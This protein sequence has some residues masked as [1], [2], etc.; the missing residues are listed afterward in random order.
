MA[1]TTPKSWGETRFAGK[2][3]PRIDGY[4]RVSG[5]ATY[6]S[7]VTL[8]DMLYGAI[9]RCPYGHA[10]VKRVDTSVARTM[11]G[12][13]AVL[14]DADQEA[15]IPWYAQP[16]PPGTPVRGTS[17]LFDPH[18]RYEGEE[19]A[20]VAAETPQQAW[21]AVR[22][23]KVEYD[24][25]PA[26]VDM[27]EALKPNA[28]RIHEA[29]NSVGPARESKRGNVELGFAE[30]DVVL[31][32]TYRTSCE[33]HTCLELHGSVVRWDG[34]RLTVWDTNQ[35]PFPIQAALASTLNMPLSKVRVIST[36]MGGGFG[37]KLVL[38][39]YTVIAALFAKKTAR[40]VKLFVTREEAFR[41]VGNRPAHVMKLKAGVKKDG[42][43][44][45]LEL[46]GTGEVG[47]YPGGTSAA[48][49]IGDLYKCA[50]V[51]V[52]ERVAMTNAG[53]QRAFR[54]PGFPQCSW[55]LEQMMDALAEKIGMDPVE[56]RLKNYTAVCQMDQNKPYTSA[57]LRECLTEGSR[58]F[59]WDEARKREKGTGPWVRG[60][61]VAAG[62]WGSQNGPP[63][64]VRVSMYPD[65]SV[66]LN[67]GAADLGTGTKTVMALVVAEELGVPLKRIDIEN[68]DTGITEFTRPSGGSKTVFADSPAVRAAALHVKEQLIEMAAAQLKTAANGLSYRDG[69]I[70]ADDG[71][72]KVAVRDL[73]QLKLQ[74][75]V[76]GIGRRGPDPVEKVVRPFVAN[77]AEVEVN[78]HTG[79][80]RVLRL[81]A[82]HDSGRVMDLLTYSNQVI[83]GL[84][85]AIGFAL[86]ERRVMDAA[87][88]KMVNANWHDYKIPTAKDVPAEKVVVPVDLHDTECNTTGTKGIGEP[89]TIPGAAAIANAFYNATGVRVTAAPITPAEALAKLEERNKGRA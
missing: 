44:T 88:G 5:T 55:A 22:A 67:M 32:E 58:A 33:L 62:M 15:Q 21:D 87:T 86:T 37:S 47:A 14:S 38:G 61:G 2:R 29:G 28:P 48:Y 76:V 65:G 71:S 59:R 30:A 45:A 6:P 16:A 12:V 46:T 70:S 64:T 85:M 9:L 8:P 43:L 75:V 26:V 27:E 53:P 41:A 4:E 89:A 51:R 63:S 66:T 17:R 35:G 36:Y 80:T 39:K 56:L 78:I 77:F 18:C 25:L 24:V 42:T 23:I 1:E 57:G 10:K 82:A 34:D 69:V 72:Q 79:E 19:V 83:G 31:E 50:N 20:A 74:Q 40:P 3:V 49:Q 11:P 84:T 7:D 54:A 13:R 68:A 60:V 73:A 81:A 52:Q